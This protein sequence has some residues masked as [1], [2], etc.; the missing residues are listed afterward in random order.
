MAKALQ[1]VDVFGGDG[2]ADAKD[3]LAARD[4]DDRGCAVDFA[5]GA[6]LA[7]AGEGSVRILEASVWLRART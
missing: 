2:F 3:D 4:A 1:E 5:E 7:G 6:E